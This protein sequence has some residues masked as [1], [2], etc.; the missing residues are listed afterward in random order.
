MRWRCPYCHDA[1]DRRFRPGHLRF[2]WGQR[3]LRR[4]GVLRDVFGLP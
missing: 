3:R 4:A 2:E 1:M